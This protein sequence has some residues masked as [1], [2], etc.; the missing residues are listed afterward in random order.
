MRKICTN[1]NEA[2]MEQ[3]TVIMKNKKRE[4]MLHRR[5]CALE[6]ENEELVKEIKRIMLK[7]ENT[8][9]KF[10]LYREDNIETVY[11]HNAMIATVNTI[12]TE[13]NYVISILSNKDEKN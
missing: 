3:L 7:Q 12:I 11:N 4:E 8:D 13:L 10:E 2:W 6:E 1:M 9:R 5:V